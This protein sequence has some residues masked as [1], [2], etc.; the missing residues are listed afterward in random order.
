MGFRCEG[1]KDTIGFLIVDCGLGG[2]GR[3]WLFS[4]SPGWRDEGD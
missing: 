4:T 3:S 2:V 1:V